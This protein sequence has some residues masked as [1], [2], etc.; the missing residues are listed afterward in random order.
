MEAEQVGIAQPE[1]GNHRHDHSGECSA[2]PSVVVRGDSYEW[3]RNTLWFFRAGALCSLGLL[4]G[5]IEMF[6]HAIG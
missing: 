6:V 2:A 4:T 5:A 1:M 3:R